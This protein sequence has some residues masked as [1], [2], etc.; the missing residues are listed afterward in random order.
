MGSAGHLQASRTSYRGGCVG[1][2]RHR[3]DDAAGSRRRGP[4]PRTGEDRSRQGPRRSEHA[5]H[6]DRK[7]AALQGTRRRRGRR[8]R[9]EDRQPRLAARFHQVGGRG[10]ALAHLGLARWRWPGWWFAC[11]AG[12]RCVPAVPGPARNCCPAMSAASTSGPKACPT[13]SATPRPHSGSAASTGPHCRCCTAARC[14]ASCTRTGCRCE[15]RAPRA[16]ACCSP[17]PGWRP[18]RRP[19]SCGWSVVWQRGG[20]RRSAA[21]HRAGAGGLRRVRSASFRRRAGRRRSGRAPSHERLAGSH[22]LGARAGGNRLLAGLRHRMGRHRNTDARERRGQEEFV[23]RRAGD[24]ARARRPGGQARQSRHHAPRAGTAGARLQPL[25]HVPRARTAPAPMGRAG[26]APRD[27]QPPRQ[28]RPAG[29]LDPA[30][31]RKAARRGREERVERAVRTQEATAQV[32]I[33]RTRQGR[34]LPCGDRARNRARELRRWPQLPHLHLVVASALPARRQAA[35]A[36][37]DRARR[38]R[39]RSDPRAGRARHRHRDALGPVAQR[40][41]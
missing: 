2:A 33:C 17:R 26:R 20:V 38:E 23:L 19:S 32:A 15:P 27:A 8:T 5:R 34:G 30:G 22:R 18:M 7:K 35:A 21:F 16:N 36:P 31:P 4:D 37:V 24:A 29:R 6:Q 40:P 11:A 9:E 1:C 39:H 3:R 12:C 25:G 13:T 10:R 14:P 28:Q 41:A